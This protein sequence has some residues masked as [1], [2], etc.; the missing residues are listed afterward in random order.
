MA[1]NVSEA[2]LVY[3]I[4]KDEPVR[5]FTGQAPSFY[6]AE[7]TVAGS[8]AL[9]LNNEI[10]GRNETAWEAL[11]GFADLWWILVHYEI[12]IVLCYSIRLILIVR[13]SI[14]GL[15]VNGTYVA[16]G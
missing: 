4:K 6:S 15:H 8:L 5:H 10:T 3:R 2:R 1:S 16:T 7:T 14:S 13:Y 9:K 11:G 12:T